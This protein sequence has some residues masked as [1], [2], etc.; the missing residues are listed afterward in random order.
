MSVLCEGTIPSILQDKNNNNKIYLHNFLQKGSGQL[1]GVVDVL[2][3]FQQ[4]QGVVADGDLYYLP[5]GMLVLLET[6]TIPT[7]TV[8]APVYGV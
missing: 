4:F 7:A 8:E 3:N 2:L 1:H 5:F 6:I